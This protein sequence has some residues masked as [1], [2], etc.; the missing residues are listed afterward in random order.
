MDFPPALFNPPPLTLLSLPPGEAL[1]GVMGPLVANVLD[2][3]VVAELI[4]VPGVVGDLRNRLHMGGVRSQPTPSLR[5][6]CAFSMEM[7]RRLRGTRRLWCC[8]CR[9]CCCFSGNC[10]LDN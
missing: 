1:L 4:K 8:C 3:V 9:C 6:V 5:P 2:A 7:E 10:S